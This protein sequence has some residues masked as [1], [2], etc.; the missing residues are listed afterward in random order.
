MEFTYLTNSYYNC[1]T[2]IAAGASSSSQNGKFICTKERFTKEQLMNAII[3]CDEGWQ[4]RPEKWPNATD[5]ATSR[6]TNTTTS[7]VLMNETWWGND[8]YA[9]FNISMTSGK[10]EDNYAE[11]ALHVRI[12]VLIEAT[13]Q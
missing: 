8:T 7:I 10:I 3:I 6:G 2:G 5:K 13:A 9:A 1:T 12:Y 4:Y 11:A